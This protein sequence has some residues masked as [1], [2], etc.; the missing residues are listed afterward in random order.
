MRQRLR[1]RLEEA[2]QQRHAQAQSHK[3]AK[4]HTQRLK[5]ALAQLAGKHDQV[6]SLLDARAEE[7]Q[8]LEAQLAH[9]GEEQEQLQAMLHEAQQQLKTQQSQ[10]A[11]TAQRLAVSEAVL[12]KTRDCVVPRLSEQGR[13][14]REQLKAAQQDLANCAQENQFVNVEYAAALKARDHVQA[15]LGTALERVAVLEAQAA[16]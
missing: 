5:A 2:A 6:H 15:Q 13:L 1:Q 14:V 9:K 3:T 16:W 10:L 7:R 11:A 8:A 12:S 4:G